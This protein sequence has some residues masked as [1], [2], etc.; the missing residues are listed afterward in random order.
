M[1]DNNLG[2]EH[3]A[4]LIF[5]AHSVVSLLDVSFDESILSRCSFLYFKYCHNTS[6]VLENGTDGC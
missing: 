4:L 5:Q 6:K 3:Q 1:C 2:G